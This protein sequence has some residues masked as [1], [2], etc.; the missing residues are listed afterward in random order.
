M[1]W[2]CTT[3]IKLK[4]VFI[5]SLSFFMQIKKNNQMKPDFHVKASEVL[6]LQE[7]IKT[8]LYQKMG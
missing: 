1:L 6:F 8:C 3:K 4:P 7:Y 2:S 5:L